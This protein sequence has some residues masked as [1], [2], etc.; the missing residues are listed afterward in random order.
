[1]DDHDSPIAMMA[2]PVES[3]F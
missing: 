3:A 2:R 1:M